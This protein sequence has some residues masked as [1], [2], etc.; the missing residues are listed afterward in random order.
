MFILKAH[1]AQLIRISYAGTLFLIFIEL[2]SV[3]G[4][5][6][7]GKKQRSLVWG[8]VK[9][10]LFLLVFYLKNLLFLVISTYNHLFCCNF[11]LLE[12]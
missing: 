1:S 7:N 6:M 9:M 11:F 3:S 8:P 12:K 10:F 2:C 4:F 5:I